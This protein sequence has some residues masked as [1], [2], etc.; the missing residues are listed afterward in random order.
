MK[1]ASSSLFT[2]SNNALRGA[3]AALALLGAGC[4]LHFKP[5][6]DPHAAPASA[7]AAMDPRV[8]FRFFDEDFVSGGF[9]YTYPDA[10]KLHIPEQSG[11][12]SEVSLQFDL[13]AGDYSGGA[14]C[15][16]NLMYDLHPY[17]SAG[18]LQFW[19]KGSRGGEVAT[20]GLVDDEARDGKKTAVRVPLNEFGGIT[21]D[22]KLVSIPLSR[23][24]R[25]GVFWD[26]KKR[27]EIPEPF[28]WTA[29]T[30]F[31]VEIKKG[32]NSAFRVWV[33]DIFVL[34]NVF[35]PV[36]E[37]PRDD[38]ED[39]QETIPPPVA[40]TDVKPVHTLF[41]DELPGGAFTYVY[42]GK[43]AAKV[44]PGSKANPG[45]LAA[46]MDGNEWSGITMNL[47][48]TGKLDLQQGRQGRWGLSFWAKG[49]PNVKSVYVGLL[50]IR[51]DGNKTQ[52]KVVL[53]DFGQL[54]T[55]WRHF[56]IPLKSFVSS[57]LYWDAGRKA[58]VSAEVDWSSIQEIRFSIGKEENRV[59]AG[60]PVSL[61]L[62][63]IAII[64]DIPGYVDPDVFWSA[65][66]SDAPE[67]M[68]HDFETAQD[69]GWEINK[70]PKSEISFQVGAG[71]KG[72]GRGRGK[73]SMGIDYRLADWCDLIFDYARHNRPAEQRD[74][75][76]YWGLR[77]SLYTDR[78]YQGVT[79]QVGDA[80]KELFIANAG[81]AAGWNEVLVPFKTFS[82][83]P[84][85]QPPDAVQNGFFDVK[86]VTSLDI[87]PAGEGSRGTFFVD[88]V[89]LTNI[90]EAPHPK[91][92]ASREFRITGDPGKV[93]TAKINDGI[94]G[95]NTA[96]WDAN[97]L[98]PNTAK[99]LKPMNHKIL[100]Y[101]G[102]LRADDDH[103]KEVLANK[104]PFVDTDE[105]LE[106]CRQTGN[107]PM[108][109]VNFGKGTPQEAA[110]WVRY[111]NVEKKAKVRYWEVG[112]EIYGDWHPQNTTGPDYGKRTV[113]FIKAMKA[114]DPTILVAVI[115]VLEGPWNQEVFAQTKDLADAV[116]IHHY[117]EAHGA[118]NDQALL[119]APQTL[120]DIIPSVRR[121]LKEFGNGKTDYQIWLT[122]WNSV[123]FRPGP[124]TLG[125][126]NALFVAD[127]LGMLARHNIEQADYWVV[128]NGLTD[129]GGDYGF[130][131]RTGDP[132]GDNVPRPS[133]YAFKLA[134]ETLRGS[135]D[136]CKVSAV[137]GG[138]NDLTC[139]LAKHADGRTALMLI[140]KHPT[141]KAEVTLDIAACKGSAT[142]QRLEAA[143]AKTGP[144][145]EKVDLKNRKI[146][147]PP[148][149]VSTLLFD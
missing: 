70:G 62:D 112:N 63:D 89:A 114:V 9:Q 18:A 21:Q 25:K 102:G 107:E 87:K 34:K 69:S 88:N 40:A 26:A 96:L 90:R 100:R 65:F 74:W 141:T 51:A 117:P 95:I 4:S 149:S 16:Y 71:P 45:V 23:F 44:Q 98:E 111:V 145:E 76:K 113:E 148:Y 92:P 13:D 27:V 75:T 136:E 94:F 7:S 57:G 143:N 104:D 120:D 81:A 130:L 55:T 126:I 72:D 14:V 147:L 61:Y 68:L 58:E 17:Y 35:A 123:D 131:T 109:T 38:W 47:G 142:W 48:T 3:V 93:I 33:D 46:Y 83:F 77:F 125:Q 41:Q 103:W 53:G 24:G 82:K 19:I 2:G 11:H 84:Y 12:A 28:D 118:E 31:R 22:W 133:Y 122:E 59:P 101:P 60:T 119:A 36:P 105:F 50:D 64:E 115:W 43:T 79:I 127:Y 124:Q 108:I 20:V 52:S 39:K 8:V 110:D 128:H 5:L 80:G 15:L 73:R 138:E 134:S 49:A 66:K 1:S 135:L 116:V 32:D 99:Y 56:R 78:P 42:G 67:L 86:G 146:S 91:A 54:D 144:Q 129:R 97:L 137:G 106:L 6:R 30:E 29:V 121:Q 85:Y 139:Y 132:L 140:N 37:I 10:S